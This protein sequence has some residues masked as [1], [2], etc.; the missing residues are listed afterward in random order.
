MKKYTIILLAVV[1]LQAHMIY[2][3][4]RSSVFP[5]ETSDT[6]PG[7]LSFGL[8]QLVSEGLQAGGALNVV[9]QDSVFGSYVKGDAEGLFGGILR[10][11]F[12]KDHLDWKANYTVIGQYSVSGDSLKVGI[13]IGTIDQKIFTSPSYVN[14]KFKKYTDFYLT[15]VR[16]MEAVYA[17]FI[18]QTTIVI[19]RAVIV[20]SKDRIRQIVADYEGYESYI[21]N[22]LTLKYYDAAMSMT[23]EKKY[24]QAIAFFQVTDNMNVQKTVN[25]TANLSK[26]YVRR[27]NDYFNLGKS[28][29]AEKDYQAAIAADANNSEAYYNLGN[30]YKDKKD[31]DAA[32]TQYK[33]SIEIDPK[34]VEALM[35]TGYV[36]IQQGR[37]SEAAVAYENAL[38][39]DDKNAAGH[40]YAGVAYDNNL[41]TANAARHYERAI[42]LDKT[43][44]GAHLNLGV[45]LK[46]R[47]NFTAARAHYESAITYDPT[48]ALAHRNLGI[49]LMNDKKEGAQAIIHLEKTL[50][51]DP[52]QDGAATIKK[53]I[54]ILKKKPAK[55]FKWPWEK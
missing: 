8:S 28:D 20:K 17:G 26:V 41:D 21:K 6:Q 4:S 23:A 55:K 27:G 40:Y 29:L 35:N 25:A 9:S 14:G 1:G 43:M 34:N 19:D 38:K 13:R 51:L 52:N 16:L 24:N 3:Q 47:K 32:L 15:A 48:N 33:K 42:E 18:S 12:L 10:P 46:M 37:N 31:Y 2:A 53:N 54:E 36:S 11:S 30:I 7:W 45:I 50:E 5:L 49:L 44:A 39:I 22:W